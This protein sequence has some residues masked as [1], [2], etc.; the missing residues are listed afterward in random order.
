MSLPD[1]ARRP[2]LLYE[3]IGDFR[4]DKQPKQTSCVVRSARKHRSFPKPL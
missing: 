3:D 1:D 4:R 2:R